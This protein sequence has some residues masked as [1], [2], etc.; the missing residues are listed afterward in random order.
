MVTLVRIPDIG[1]HHDVPV[2]EVLVRPGDAVAAGDP[3]V[4]LES[5]KATMEVPSPVAGIVRALSVTV[6]DHVSQG[7]VILELEGG[8]DIAEAGRPGSKPSPSAVQHSA[9]GSDV[10]PGPTAAQVGAT[11][12]RAAAGPYCGPAV[13]RMA[14]EMGVNLTAVRGSG[15][16][17]R[18]VKSD[19]VNHLKSTRAGA[20][21][22]TLG[23]PRHAE[24]AAPRYDF[25]RYGP[26]EVQPLTR[27][28]RISANNLARNWATIP[29]VT[30]HHEADVTDLEAFRKRVNGEAGTDG[31][32]VTLLAFVIRACAAALRAHPGFNAS[33]DGDNLVLKRY[34]HVGFAVDTPGGLVVPVI[35]DA[36]RKGVREIAQESAVLAERARRGQV[37]AEEMQGGCFTVSSLGADGGAH[38]TPI[39]NAPEVAVLGLSATVMQPVWTGAEFAPRL[40]LPLSLSWDHRAL[41]GAAAARFNHFMVTV[42]GDFRRLL[43]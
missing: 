33:L 43:L 41:D 1:D 37:K 21:V 14:R 40:M 36:D 18:I 15:P 2:I 30:N 29:H 17:G 6:G 5:D 11:G 13:R 9:G 35:R 32:K 42:L 31:A 20:L 10:N 39:I 38:F 34:V 7:A 27:I 24:P 3:L 23:V 26:V 16:R 28:R 25:A 19:V 22:E 12:P 8:D 4:T